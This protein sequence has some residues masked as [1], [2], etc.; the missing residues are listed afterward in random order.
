MTRKQPAEP[1]GF[2]ATSTGV[3]GQR[4]PIVISILLR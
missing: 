4:E 2:S 1:V 3:S